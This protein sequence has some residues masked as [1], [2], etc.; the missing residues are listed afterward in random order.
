MIFFFIFTN[1]MFVPVAEIATKRMR[2]VFLLELHLIEMY[3][4]PTAD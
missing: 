1:K 4:Y 3:Q 2:V